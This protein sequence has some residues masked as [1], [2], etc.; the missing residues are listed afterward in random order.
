MNREALRRLAAP[1]P[2]EAIEWRI[3]RAGEK[4]GRVWAMCVPYGDP[5]WLM[6]R[7][8]AV[9]GPENWRDEYMPGPDGGVKCRLSIRVDGEWIA[10]E[11]GAPNTDIEAVKGGYT[12]AFRRAC[13]KWNVGSIRSL[14]EL[15]DCFAE[16]SDSGKHRGSYKE[17]GAQYP[18]N[19][20][21]DPPRV[22]LPNPYRTAKVPEAA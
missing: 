5:R 6:S 20:R 19:F 11:D 10:K 21:W 13:V 2:A 22:S 3:Q 17:K 9:V 16:V 7:L 8:D 18:K 1:M 14:Y 12:D 15:N 4:N